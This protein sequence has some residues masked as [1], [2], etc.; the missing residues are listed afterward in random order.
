VAK[1]TIGTSK[2]A[3]RPEIVEEVVDD[4]IEAVV[5]DATDA[6]VEDAEIVEA[7]D[8]AVEILESD[9]VDAPEAEGVPVIAS[10]PIRETIVERK[11]G[12]V[13]LVLGGIVAAGIG[14]AS[15]EYIFPDGLPFGSAATE[16][17][18]LE[19]ALK[20]QTGRID[21]LTKQLEAQPTVDTAALDA[22]VA[23]VGDLQSQIGTVADNVTGLEARITDLEARPN[24]DGS[25]VSAAMEKEL[26]DLRA[27]LDVQKGE[28][29]QMI[30]E[31]QSKKQSAEDTARQSRARGAVTRILVALEGG[32]PFADALADVE[33]N[34]DIDVAEALVQTA[35]EGVPTLAA[36]N[37]SYPDAARAA[38]AAVRA[39]DTGG[40]V[41]S[42]FAKQFGTR[43]VAPREGDDPDAVLSRVGAA[44]ETGNIAD[45]LAEADALPDVAKAELA[46]WTVQ[47]DLRLS[48]AREAE[49]LANSL[50]TQ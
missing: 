3:Q 17:L 44:V 8:D 18:D 33:A 39:G 50:N 32:A 30:D 16:K 19:S 14:I 21:D 48:A 36:L 13:P 35:A 45:A 10:E 6:P 26:V 47:A 27:S 37:E 4:T 28:L 22:A 5:E 41:G 31:A 12:F 7:G 1:P 43:S 20:L 11:S 15:A 42:F 40:G 34:S 46:D 9:P 23:A 2:K 38:L 24:S 49:A 29:A 25:G